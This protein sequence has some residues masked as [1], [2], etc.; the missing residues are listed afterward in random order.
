MVGQA[1][2]QV[3]PIKLAGLRDHADLED[4]DAPFALER[5]PGVDIGVMVQLGDDDRIAC[6]ELTS[7]V[8]CAR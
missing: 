1:A 3:V 7:R 8:P 6:P 2:I 5:A 4:G